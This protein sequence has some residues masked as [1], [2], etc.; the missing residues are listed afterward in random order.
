MGLELKCRCEQH[1]CVWNLNRNW[2]VFF[3][4]APS[5]ESRWGPRWFISVPAYTQQCSV[6][7]KHTPAKDICLTLE[8]KTL[9]YEFSL[10]LTYFLI[11]A[12]YKFIQIYPYKS[13]FFWVASQLP[14]HP[15]PPCI[16]AGFSFA[17]KVAPSFRAEILSSWKPSSNACSLML[18]LLVLPGS[19]THSLLTRLHPS[20]ECACLA[21]SRLS[22]SW[23]RSSSLPPSMFILYL[24]VKKSCGC[25][26]CTSHC[27][28]RDEQ[29]KHSVNI[30][31]A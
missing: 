3:W 29:E 19:W 6:A 7:P 15:S 8:F 18:P 13:L 30:G 22:D 4:Q 26:L 17:L 25:L 10:L 5:P 9:E 12:E 2:V 16:C 21:H 1:T 20:C 27:A 11:I 28:H 23:G 31:W 24:L 14:L